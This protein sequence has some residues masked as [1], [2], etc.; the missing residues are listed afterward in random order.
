MFGEFGIDNWNQASGMVGS[1]RCRGCLA[2]PRCLFVR[3]A[4]INN[5]LTHWVDREILEWCVSEYQIKFRSGLNRGNLYVNSSK[6][7]P[8]GA[9][10][11]GG[12]KGDGNSQLSPRMS[13]CNPKFIIRS[14]RSSLLLQAGYF[15]KW[16]QPILR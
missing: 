7:F 9:L 5:K 16:R 11:I 6:M 13:T 10:I 8:N 4:R 2:E 1:V 12:R 14:G 15:G 3:L